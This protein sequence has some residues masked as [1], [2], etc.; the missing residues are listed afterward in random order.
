MSAVNFGPDD[1]QFWA[2]SF[3]EMAKYDL[4]AQINFVIETAGVSEIFYAGHSEGTTQAF[5]GFSIGRRRTDNQTR[6]SPRASPLFL[7]LLLS[8]TLATASQ[9]C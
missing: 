2:F 7:P 3:D 8:L 9:T 1:A 4:P 6:P 5:A